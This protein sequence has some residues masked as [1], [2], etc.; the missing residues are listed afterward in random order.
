MNE[1]WIEWVGY[2]GSFLILLSMTMTSII[3]LRWFNLSGAAL[4]SVYGFIIGAMPVALMNLC[5]T[6]INIFHLTR[7]YRK[8][9]PN[10]QLKK[11]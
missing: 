4:F 7:I 5:I 8:K 10:N 3:R 11:Q 6:L 1:D 2:A 9:H